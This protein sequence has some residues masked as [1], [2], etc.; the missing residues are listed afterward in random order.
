MNG[1][2]IISGCG[3]RTEKGYTTS[4]DVVFN[5]EK[6]DKSNL[7]SLEDAKGFAEWCDNTGMYYKKSDKIWI[8][9]CETEFK[10]TD[11]LFQIYLTQKVAEVPNEG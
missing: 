5:H 8:S 10:N 2:L 4:F 7:I 6:F 3:W 9:L 11:Q 1:E